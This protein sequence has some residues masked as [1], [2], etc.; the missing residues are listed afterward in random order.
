MLGMGVGW[1]AGRP[2]PGEMWYTWS[3]SPCSWGSV[4]RH[5]RTFLLNVFVMLICALCNFMGTT[6]AKSKDRNN[7]YG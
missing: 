6:W 3:G 1:L 4:A 7:L 5:Q 2:C